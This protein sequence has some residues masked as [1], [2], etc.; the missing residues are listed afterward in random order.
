MPKAGRLSAGWVGTLAVLL[1][2]AAAMLCSVSPLRAEEMKIGVIYSQ[3]GKYATNGQHMRNGV[4]L[5]AQIVE[6]DKGVPL[7]GRK[8]A[9]L[10]PV[11]R[12]DES[13]IAR[14]AQ[15]V[16]RMLEDEDIRVFLG[17]FSAGLSE[18]IAPLTEAERAPLVLYNG[19]VSAL[20]SRPYTSVYALHSLPES[21][22]GA[23]VDRIVAAE[24]SAGRDVTALT[25][26]LVA[27]SDPY[28]R[29]VIEGARVALEKVDVR[30]VMDDEI[31]HRAKDLSPTLIRV[32]AQ[33]PDILLVSGHAAVARVLM[34][35]VRELQVAV[36]YLG[37]T[38]CFAARIVEVD[39]G[40]A[41]N[42][43]CPVEW[44]QGA[45]GRVERMFGGG[46][47]FLDRFRDAY[48]Y[49]PPPIAAQ[50]AAAF[51]LIAD[52]IRRAGSIDPA[53]VR[54]TLSEIDT[55]TINGRVRFDQRGRNTGRTAR[56]VRITE[57]GS[58]L[59]PATGK[60][61]LP[62]REPLSKDSDEDADKT[63]E[64]SKQ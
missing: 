50:A 53:R 2:S 63:T 29:I 51:Q 49:T 1:L 11:F 10:I 55:L 28:S 52:A 25:A 46:E 5:A 30:I 8:R 40:A 48:G 18:A 19:S 14:G 31:E 61:T 35:Q 32:K 59:V 26:G 45:V 23:V 44:H 36:P 21:Y 27:A 60:I 15:I 64:G 34:R 42:T 7:S 33:Q 57:S 12:D 43:L 37:L 47:N 17:P 41:A 20:M 54:S 22:L 3:T 13:D 38:H 6:E 24:E 16:S 39:A 58:E 56:V 4:A 62:L 9:N